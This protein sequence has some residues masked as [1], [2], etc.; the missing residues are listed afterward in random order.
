MADKYDMGTP[1]H[2]ERPLRRRIF[3]PLHAMDDDYSDEPV[4]PPAAKAAA[5]L[6]IEAI[7]SLLDKKFDERLQPV[8]NA[9]SEMQDDTRR[10]D[11]NVDNLKG[12]V[13]KVE[14]GLGDLAARVARME[15]TSLTLQPEMSSP[16]VENL[17][18]Q[19]E[20]MKVILQGNSGTLRS[21]LAD[22]HTAVV[23]GF[24]GARDKNELETWLSK[25]CWSAHAPQPT[26]TYIKGD[27]ANF[28]GVAFGKYQSQVERDAAV[29]KIQ[30]AAFEFGGQKVWAKPELP[31]QI[32]VIKGLLFAAKQMFVDW[33]FEKRSLW[34]DMEEQHLKCGE[35]VVLKVEIKDC[36]LTITYDPEWQTYVET[37]N[38]SWA[39]VIK[40]A[41]AKLKSH[42][43][44][45]ATK[46][47]GK[48]KGKAKGNHES[49]GGLPSP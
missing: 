44:Q 16:D 11:S 19:L 4:T 22:G 15:T 41:V 34:V 2:S 26:E 1:L 23:G 43:S 10:I 48:G 29:A 7:A 45:A 18:Q 40:E 36:E 47:L 28:N 37:G 49:S 27:M 25:V 13:D 38:E 6:T 8:L 20:A 12:R 33:R 31:L 3:S 46:G 14:D 39:N 24:K 9:M 42:T 5:P 30:A 35:D 32:R 21:Q 17:R